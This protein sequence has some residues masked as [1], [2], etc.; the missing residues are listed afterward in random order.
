MKEKQ[1]VAA[2]DYHRKKMGPVKREHLQNMLFTQN[3]SSNN[4]KDAV[5]VSNC[6]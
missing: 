1:F 6:K 5:C 3:F 2:F 4:S